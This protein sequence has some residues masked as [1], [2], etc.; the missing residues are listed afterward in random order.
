[1][2]HTFEITS[3]RQTAAPASSAVQVPSL[4]RDRMKGA[5]LALGRARRVVELRR[6]ALADARKKFAQAQQAL[7]EVVNVGLDSTEANV[8]MIEAANHV[9]EIERA[10]SMAEQRED[11]ARKALRTAEM[12]V[13]DER[14]RHIMKRLNLDIAPKAEKILKDLEKF[15]ESEFVPALHEARAACG[16]GILSQ[17]ATEL[18][19]YWG[20]CVMRACRLLAQWERGAE[21]QI[22]GK[23][24][25]S[26]IPERTSMTTGGR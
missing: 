25:S 16:P 20:P 1:M 7:D 13:S 2:S 8:E 5:Q 18:S 21:V 10:V 3:S 14:E 22:E 24:F 19:L 9:Q 6:A 4:A 26:H 11:A 12:V 15:V 17:V 23:P